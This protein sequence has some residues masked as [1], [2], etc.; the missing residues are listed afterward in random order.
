MKNMKKVLWYI[1]VSAMV[2]T[3]FVLVSAKVLAH[4]EGQCLT[5]VDGNVFR[6]NGGWVKVIEHLSDAD[7]KEFVHGHRHQ[8]YDRHG[9]P[10]GQTTNFW[11]IYVVADDSDY[12]ADCPPVRAT[13]GATH[14]NT[15][16]PRPPTEEP[17][18]VERSSAG[19]T[20]PNT[21][22][23]RPS[24]PT[25]RPSTRP[26]SSATPPPAETIDEV[27]D[28]LPDPDEQPAPPDDTS[29]IDN[30]VEEVVEAAP[31][32]LSYHEWTWLKG[33]NL[34]SF[35]VMKPEIETVADLYQAYYTLF[36][37]PQDII[38]VVIDGCWFGYNGQ[39]GQVAGDVRITPYLGVLML[40]DW[41]ATLTMRGVEQI[42]DGEVELMPGLNVVGLSELPSRYRVPSDFLSID[43]IEM[44]MTTAWNDEKYMSDLRLIGRASDPG[45]NPLYRGQAVILIATVQLTLDL[46]GSVPS[47]PSIKRKRTLATT[48]GA[49]KQ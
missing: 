42:G 31:M 47:A 39:E 44:V 36:N 2:L 29:M 4:D 35:P 26:P 33:Y 13:A 7:L 22:I 37:P 38:Y 32:K 23:P 18:A 34:V 16:V 20:H 10:T 24:T 3:M 6:S 17:D 41:S 14:P 9:N 43:G 5:D 46:S 25:P 45:D 12:L 21:P 19:A 40:M 48:W 15:P 28:Q 8:Y 30:P 1:I 11:S 27:K 49:M